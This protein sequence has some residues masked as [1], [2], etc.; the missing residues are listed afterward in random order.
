[1]GGGKRKPW[2]F[3]WPRPRYPGDKDGPEE[4]VDVYGRRDISFRVSPMP[5]GGFKV[6]CLKCG[7]LVA[8]ETANTSKDIF[9]HEDKHPEERWFVIF[10]DGDDPQLLDAGLLDHREYLLARYP[11]NFVDKAAVGD[12]CYSGRLAMRLGRQLWDD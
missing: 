9:A 4:Q 6:V 7:G 2:P 11:A 8:L 1:M 3:P 5:S 10:N 12:F